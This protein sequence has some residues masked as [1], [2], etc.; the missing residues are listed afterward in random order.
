MFGIVFEYL[1]GILLIA[2]KGLKTRIVLIAEKFMFT[3]FK[4]YSNAPANT[5][6]RSKRFHESAKY[7]P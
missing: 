6:K 1:L 7:A 5:M 4:K 2:L 3:S